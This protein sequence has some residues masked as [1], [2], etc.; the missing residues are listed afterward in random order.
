MPA[1]E[2]HVSHMDVQVGGREHYPSWVRPP[3]ARC[4]RALLHPLLASVQCL[5]V[6]LPTQHILWSLKAGGLSSLTFHLPR[7]REELDMALDRHG[8][9]P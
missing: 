2:E 3:A 5:S 1:L 6:F 4:T 7:P 8:A 9:L